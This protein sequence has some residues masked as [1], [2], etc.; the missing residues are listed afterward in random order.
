MASLEHWDAGSI[1]SSAQWVKDPVL[2]RWGTGHNCGS[3]LFPGPGTPYAL[4]QPKKKK[5][6]K[7]WHD[8]CT[9][10]WTGKQILDKANTAKH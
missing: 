5:K 2:P 6:K 4:G 7:R 9:E 8:G 1:P 10:G 3:D